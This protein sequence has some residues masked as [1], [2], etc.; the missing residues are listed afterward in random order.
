MENKLLKKLYSFYKNKKAVTLLEIIIAFLILVVAA[1]GASGII[2]H[3]HR[4]TYQDF[5]RGEALQIL[6]DRMNFLSSVSFKNLSEDMG[7]RSPVT[8]DIKYRNI[9]FGLITIGNNKYEVIATLNYQPITFENLMELDFNKNLEKEIKYEYDKPNTWYFK[10]K[11]NPSES[12]DKSSGDYAYAVIKIKV[13]VKPVEGR[14]TN[15]ERTYEAITFV[16]NTE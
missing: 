4:A 7:G 8:I 3:G 2:S 13:S 14:V 1:L 9:E 10:N 11:K 15:N 12:Y 5:R 6:V 16:C